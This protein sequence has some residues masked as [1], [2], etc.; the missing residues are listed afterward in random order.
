MGAGYI[1]VYECSG[2]VVPEYRAGRVSLCR[3]LEYLRE[4]GMSTCERGLEYLMVK[5]V[6]HHGGGMQTMDLGQGYS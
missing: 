1:E 2:C 5:G 6:V 3:E 4:R